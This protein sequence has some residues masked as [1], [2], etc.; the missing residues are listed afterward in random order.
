MSAQGWSAATTLGMN[1]KSTKSTLKGFGGWRTLSGFNQSFVS[2]NPG[3]S[4]R[5][6][7]GLRLANALGV[8]L[9]NALLPRKLS[10][11]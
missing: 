10:R 8:Y 9:P 2:L 1:H 3:F 7:P 6:N 11:T 4:L 5:S